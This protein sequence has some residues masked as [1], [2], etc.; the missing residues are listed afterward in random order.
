MNRTFL[1][2]SGVFCWTVVAIDAA[3][4]VVNGDMVVP[5]GMAIVFV[6]W[7]GLRQLQVRQ[8]QRQTA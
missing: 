6:L 8:R 3:V 2:V 7:V 4:H 1:L 5:T